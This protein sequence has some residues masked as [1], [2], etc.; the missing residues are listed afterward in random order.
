MQMI[1][2]AD[3]VIPVAH[4]SEAIDAGIRVIACAWP[5]AVFQNAD[6]PEIVLQYDQLNQR[7]MNEVFIYRNLEIAKQWDELGAVPQLA[8]TMIHI[9]KGNNAL[10]VVTD[11]PNEMEMRA[12]IDAILQACEPVPYASAA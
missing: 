9:V 1:G 12:I 11:D 7:A 8:N 10:T 3:I 5:D 4:E 6:C 2:G